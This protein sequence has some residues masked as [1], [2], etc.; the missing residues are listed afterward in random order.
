MRQVDRRN[1]F[2]C[3]VE[4]VSVNANRQDRRALIMRVSKMKYAGVLIV[5][6]GVTVTL[7]AGLACGTGTTDFTVTSS[8]DLNHSHRV[9]ISG[10][11][12]DDPPVQKT[13]TTTRDGGVPHTHT[14]TLT[15]QEYEAIKKGQEIAVVSSA[16]PDNNHT[17]TFDIQAPAD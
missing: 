11:D 6:M 1:L 5:M 12:L 9:I 15:K 13:L 7:L 3:S 4:A 14:I 2:L 17:H 16:F 10:D 8:T